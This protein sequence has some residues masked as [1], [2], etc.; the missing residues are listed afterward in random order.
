MS[1]SFSISSWRFEGSESRVPGVER[2][3][4]PGLQ[5]LGADFVRPQPPSGPDF[6]LL[7]IKPRKAL[8]IALFVVACGGR[9]VDGLD[10]FRQ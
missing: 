8:A 9:Q 10:V 2:S 4:P 1:D 3:E 7:S 5:R 6:Q